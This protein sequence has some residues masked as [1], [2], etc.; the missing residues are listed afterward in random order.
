[1]D[2]LVESLLTANVEANGKAGMLADRA[3]KAAADFGAPGEAS[4]GYEPELARDNNVCLTRRA[5]DG[6]YFFAIGSR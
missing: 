4:V 2:E 3:P 5:L 6:N 1:M